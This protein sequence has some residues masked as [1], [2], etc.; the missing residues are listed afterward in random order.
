[1]PELPE[2]ETVCRGLEQK[3]RGARFTKIIQRRQDL[4]FPLPKNLPQTLTGCRIL[5]LTRRAK[6]IVMAVDNGQAL[7]LHLG[8]SGRLVLGLGEVVPEKHDHLIFYFDNGVSLRFHDPRRFGMLDLVKEGDLVHHKCL[9]GLGIEP[10]GKELTSAYLLR[11]LAGRKTSLKAALLDQ[12]LIVGL[13]NIYVSEALYHAGLHPERAAGSLSKAEAQRLVVAIRK[14]LNAAIEAG[15]SSLRDYVQSNGELGYFQH[16][17]A[18]YDREGQACPAC[19]C[20]LKKTG[21]IRRIMQ[22]GRSTFFCPRKQN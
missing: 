15:G 13:G 4:R 14:V 18:V 8:M 16:H 17:F 21:G 20:N 7:L 2:V 11:M 19:D 5:T 1:M 10:L 3:L 22:S 6:Y 12:R 9:K